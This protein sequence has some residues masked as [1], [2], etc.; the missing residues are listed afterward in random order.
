MAPTRMVGEDIRLFDIED[1]RA[2]GTRYK[3]LETWFRNARWLLTQTCRRVRAQLASVVM[4]GEPS[5]VRSHRQTYCKPEIPPTLPF[6]SALSDKKSP[7][8]RITLKALCGQLGCVSEFGTTFF[9]N[10]NQLRARQMMH[11]GDAFSKR[12]VEACVT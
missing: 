7:Q 12:D 3:G 2:T 5:I 1:D 4:D 10:R 11:S 8:W 6:R 9:C